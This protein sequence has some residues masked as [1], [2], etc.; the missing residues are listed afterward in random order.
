MRY[1]LVAGLFF[2][3]TDAAVAQNTPLTCL[4]A[5][6]GQYS[7]C[8]STC[9]ITGPTAGTIATPSVT[10]QGPTSNQ[11]Q[12]VLNCTTQRQLCQSAC[13]RQ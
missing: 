4:M 3:A 9:T 5:C 10:T 2:I 7:T 8:Q 12:C 1:L 13:Y 11:T 6:T